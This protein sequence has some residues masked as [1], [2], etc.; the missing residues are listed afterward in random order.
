VTVEK[1]IDTTDLEVKDIDMLT[2]TVR[3]TI[4]RHL[5]PEEGSPSPEPHP[6]NPS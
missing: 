2:R 4:R 5:T 1:P 6:P 3:E